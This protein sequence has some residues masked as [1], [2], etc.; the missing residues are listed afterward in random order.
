M[1]AE[2]NWK[3]C[4]SQV[5]ELQ[6][7]LDEASRQSSDIGSQKARLSQDITELQRQ[8]EEA[9]S[10]VGQ[11]TKAKQQ[12]ASQLEEARRNLDEETRVSFAEDMGKIIPVTLK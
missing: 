5:A 1:N 9:E 12:L 4:E 3:T 11:L 2:K 10:Q 8:L 6:A 7:R